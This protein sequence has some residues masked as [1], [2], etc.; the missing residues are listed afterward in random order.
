MA[1]KPTSKTGS[2]RPPGR[3]SGSKAKGA[4]STFLQRPLVGDRFGSDLINPEQVNPVSTDNS[5]DAELVR[6]S[7]RA[8]LRDDL[9][10]AAAKA[11]AART[12]AEITGI[13]GRNAKPPSDGGKPLT[14]MTRSE[15]EAELAKEG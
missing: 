13:L 10:S 2:K 5:Q 8:I 1:T 12:L 3:P 6:K 9:A 11:S 14:E 7:L 15:L 4:D